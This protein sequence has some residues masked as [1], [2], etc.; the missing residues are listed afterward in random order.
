MNYPRIWLLIGS[1]L[2]LHYQYSTPLGTGLAVLF[3]ATCLLVVG[4]LNLAEGITFGILLCSPPIM[5]GVERGNIDLL[6]F[7]LLGVALTALANEQFSWRCLSY[8]LV[9]IAGI[10]K[11]YP[12]CGLVLCCR[13]KPRQ[14]LWIAVSF[15]FAFGL[16]LAL[17]YHDL[18]LINAGTRRSFLA[19]YGSRVLFD[20]LLGHHLPRSEFQAWI[21]VGVASL[22]A[23]FVAYSLIRIQ[24]PAEAKDSLRLGSTLYVATFLLGNNWNYRLIMLL[25]TVPGIFAALR[26]KR[27]LIIGVLLLVTI[28]SMLLLSTSVYT[29]NVLFYIKEAIAWMTFVLLLGVVIRLL[30]ESLSPPGWLA[31]E[32]QTP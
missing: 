4:R 21:A 26:D 14:L 23:L 32:E 20:R 15:V 6:A 16:Y 29:G 18:Q 3:F 19:S 1:L 24:I 30:V 17:T 2:H 31:R 8:C 12:A 11:L 25:F 5:L 10:L 7:I 9:F 27:S 13:E 28:M 22:L